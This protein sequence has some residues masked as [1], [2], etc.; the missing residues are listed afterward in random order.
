[1]N[2]RLGKIVAMSRWGIALFALAISQFAQAAV[3]VDDA[4]LVATSATYLDNAPAVQTFTVTAATRLKLTLTDTTPG[5][6]PR[7]STVDAVITNGSAQVVHLRQL[8][9]VEFDAEPGTYVVHVLATT[10]QVG[11][12]GV[13]IVQVSDDANI[14]TYN[15]QIAG[16][17]TGLPGNESTIQDTVAVGAAGT[18]DIEIHDEQIPAA[19]SG[20]DL[21]LA[22]TG[23]S[24]IRL[25]MP[26]MPTDPIPCTATQ[27]SASLNAGSYDLL[28]DVIAS[29]QASA[30]LYTIDIRPHGSATP[31]YSRAT[32]IGKLTA[33]GSITIPS[34]GQYTM[35]LTDQ[36]FPNALPSVKAVLVQNG[37]V[38]TSA[39]A[40]ATTSAFD[41]VAGDATIYA[42]DTS[43]TS[44]GVGSFAVSL[45]QGGSTVVDKVVIVNSASPG[46][47]HAYAFDA[48]VP[49][50]QSAVQVKDFGIYQTLNTLRYAVVQGGSM[51]A[52]TNAGTSST[53]TLTAGAATVVV[54]ADLAA[55]A[56]TGL[57]GVT[58]DSPTST[59][60]LTVTQGVGDFSQTRALTIGQTAT[61]DVSTVDV[62]FPATFDQFALV[63]IRDQTQVGYIIGADTLQ[64]LK[65]TSGD[66]SIAIVAKANGSAHYGLYGLKIED[67]P[68]PTL[69]LTAPTTS[70]NS[71]GSVS[72]TWNTQNADSCTA[73]GGWSGTKGTSGSNVSV[74]P[75][76]SSTT[77]T[78][79][80]AGPG[81]STSSNLNVVVNGGATNDG[82]GGGAL[83]LQWLLALCGLAF[84]RRL[85]RR[86]VE[87]ESR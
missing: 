25:C 66:Y 29:S 3:Y 57:F 77:L 27:T 80:C 87:L 12:L 22:D 35:T 38:L 75:I 50:G 51:S 26:A 49:A 59:R 48:T 64:G 1:M 65:L 67:T 34:D 56:T 69:V 2:K 41:A 36:Q 10:S 21:L 23:G 82:G 14:L 40:G 62:G 85:H 37:R 81:G 5:T 86:A 74:G 19:L 20:M 17:L 45:Q 68:P 43:T 11:S 52:P 9:S 73:S 71:Q 58:V 84:G 4:Q 78:L 61:V 8:G 28:A 7:L 47:T 42:V 83:T 46:V 53:I 15:A 13:G 63:L 24:T 30:G 6:L 31:L 44:T 18:Y 33:T 39:A 55:T 60:L 70:I 76:G 54:A 32:A 72:L 16:N 79:T